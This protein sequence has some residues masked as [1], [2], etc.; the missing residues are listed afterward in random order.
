MV[1]KEMQ[2]QI[3]VGMVKT[4]N[5]TRKETELEKWRKQTKSRAGEKRTCE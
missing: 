2:R 5:N 4:S 3:M 1:I